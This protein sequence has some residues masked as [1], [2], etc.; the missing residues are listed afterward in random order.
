MLKRFNIIRVVRKS[1][2]NFNKRGVIV[3]I[4]KSSYYPYKVCFGVDRFDNGIIGIYFE[5][6]LEV[7][8]D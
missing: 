2:T 1:D 4:V 5:S 8:D 3:S 7:E 6:D